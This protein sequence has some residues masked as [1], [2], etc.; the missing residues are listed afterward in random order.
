[1]DNMNDLDRLYVN[2]HL[3]KEIENLKERIEHLEHY[4]GYYL[5]QIRYL[6]GLIDNAIDLQEI[7][8]RLE[9]WYDSNSKIIEDKMSE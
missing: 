2:R 6:Y 8:H 7:Q 3:K 4:N 5:L 9:H 1:M